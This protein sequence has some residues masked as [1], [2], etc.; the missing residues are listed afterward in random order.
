MANRNFL[1]RNGRLEAKV[2]LRLGKLRRVHER[3]RRMSAAWAV[4]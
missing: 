1:E 4:A 3:N 2:I